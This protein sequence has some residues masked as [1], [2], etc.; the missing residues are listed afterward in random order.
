MQVKGRADVADLD[1]ARDE[2]RSDDVHIRFDLRLGIALEDVLLDGLHIA[3]QLAQFDRTA[4]EPS[5]E[6]GDAVRVHG[7]GLLEQ[8]L[9]LV[10]DEFARGLLHDHDFRRGDFLGTHRRMM[11][12]SVAASHFASAVLDWV[13][14]AM[15]GRVE[16]H[17]R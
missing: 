8:G 5:S 6:R 12:R 17:T 2:R 15:V 9:G 7:G 1:L 11:S 16:R 14:D 3:D 4:V 10:G 13:A